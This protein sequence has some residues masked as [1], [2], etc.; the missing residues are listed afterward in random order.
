[1]AQ[2]QTANIVDKLDRGIGL[3]DVDT[4]ATTCTEVDQDFRNDGNIIAIIVNNSAGVRTAT[5][6]SQP[7]SFGR[8]GATDTD[9]DEVLAIPAT[10]MG[11]FPMMSSEMFNSGSVSRIVL[12]AF[13][14]TK[15]LLI[16]VRKAR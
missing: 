12:D 14:T 11:F 13:A 4:A 5:L 2:D 15:I 16:R 3:A 7:D 1:M 9:N 8:G 10:S 6:K